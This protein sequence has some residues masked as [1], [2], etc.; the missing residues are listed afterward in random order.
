VASAWIIRRERN[1][2]R[3]Y[4]VRYRLGGR[5][6]TQLHG[7]AFRLEREARARRDWIAGELAA[8]RVPDLALLEPERPETFGDVAERWRVSRVDVADGT[9]AT[10]VVNLGRI[11][12]H[13]GDV[14]I[15]RVGVPE[16][17]D[18]IGSLV[19][20]KLARE[21][22][23]KTRS[24]LAMVLDFAGV[25]PN[26]ARDKSVKLPRA[27][28]VELTPPTADHVEAVHAILS[29][30]NATALLVLDATGMRVTE[31]ER[32]LW[33]DVDEPAGR[34][35]VRRSVSK[36]RQARW[37]PVVP[38]E[39]F[40]A[41]METVPREDRDLSAQV[42][43]GFGADRFRTAL[44]R[45]CRAAGVPEFSPHDLRHRRATL[46][47]VSGVPVVDAAA[48]LGHSPTEHLRTYAHASL[49][50]RRE[51]GYSSMLRSSASRTS[52]MA[53]S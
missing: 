25:Q 5:E 12:P 2:R 39:L 47:H 29:G 32:L 4:V 6:A 23:R 15:D 1:G 36:T 9:A 37:V 34:W 8:L 19:K 33:G 26:P 11:L 20:E 51:V 21:S 14:P 7:G 22:I 13:L 18:L 48:W 49:S 17:S 31:L 3:T 43:E 50:E 16:V 27:E 30:V 46:W 44:T 45:A 52:M 38:V 41:L 24:T 28:H 42:L 10:H 53:R 40:D 35:R